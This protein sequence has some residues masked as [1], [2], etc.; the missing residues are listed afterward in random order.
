M[1]YDLLVIGAGPAGWSAA[2]QGA[3]LGLE[4]AVVERG[5]MLGGACVQTGTLPSKALRHTVMELVN[6]RRA[7]Q[8]GVHATQLRPLSINDLRGP[9]DMLIANH[10]QTIRSFFDRNRVQVLAG[11]ASFVARDR[12][13][14]ANREGEEIVEADHVVIATGSRPRRP[15]ELPFD[16]RVIVDSDT[17]LDLDSIPRS[18]AV[19]GS[20]VIG[21]EYATVFAMLGTRVTIIDRRDKLLRDLDGDV[22]DH[23]RHSMFSMGIRVLMP[24]RISGVRIETQKRH[25]EG[26]VYLESGRTVR[27]ERVLV[28]A[29]RVS[30]VE[31][32]DL[33]RVGIQT[34][35]SGLIKVDACFRTEV[36]NVFAVGDVIGFPALASTSMHQGRLA[37]L[38]A[39]GRP[40]PSTSKLPMAIYTIPEISAVGLT[41][42]QCRAEGIPYEIGIARTNETPRGQIVRDEGL[43]KLIFRRDTREVVG[44]HMIGIAA[45]ELI[46][47]GLML[48]QMGGTLDDLQGAVFNYPT[49]SETYRIAALDGLNRL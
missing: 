36:E 15:P 7:A 34:N 49:M 38:N 35:E 18:L 12:V 22:L 19:V 4:V 2:L 3:K 27:T 45:S 25:R 8:L 47:I 48:V 9:R 30:N 5:L 43:L 33:G 10:Q 37:V 40:C 39:L 41:E 23:L 26:V 46:H 14:I 28:A 42:E 29:G 24:E 1:R 21:C 11:S 13:R 17:L 31:A 16:D 32:L 44:V 6:S 20:G